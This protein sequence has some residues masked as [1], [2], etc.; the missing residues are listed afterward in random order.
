MTPKEKKEEK[1]KKLYFGIVIL[2]LYLK[3]GKN[4]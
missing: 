4:V 2:F 1:H 3:S